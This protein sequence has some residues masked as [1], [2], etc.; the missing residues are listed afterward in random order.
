MSIRFKAFAHSAGRAR[1]SWLPDR[2]AHAYV[3]LGIQR[4]LVIVAV[5]LARLLAHER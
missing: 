1:H 5:R 4:P 3:Q 2:R